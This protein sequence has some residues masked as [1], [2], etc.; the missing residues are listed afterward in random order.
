MKIAQVISGYSLGEADLLR[1]AIG[2]KIKSEL[3]SQKENFVKGAGNKKIKSSD[4]S[5]LIWIFDKGY[6]DGSRSTPLM[7]V[8]LLEE[9]IKY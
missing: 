4:A 7:T 6:V 8:R 9:R 5:K 3:L 2:K 1:R